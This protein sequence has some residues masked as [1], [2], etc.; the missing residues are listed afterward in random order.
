[1]FSNSQSTVSVTNN[2][3]PADHQY[4]IHFHPFYSSVKTV[5]NDLHSSP[6]TKITPEMNQS[7]CKPCICD[8]IG[9]I[10]KWEFSLGIKLVQWL[11]FY[12]SLDDQF[13]FD[14]AIFGQPFSTRKNF[15]KKELI[16]SKSFVMTVTVIISC[17]FE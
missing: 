8:E 3:L 5:K 11:K 2:H 9:T 13:E 1:M 14:L 7:E 17:H 15:R 6:L 12:T 10:Y 4:F 16:F